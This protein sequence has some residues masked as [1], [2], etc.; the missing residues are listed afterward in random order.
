[1][2]GKGGGDFLNTLGQLVIPQTMAGMQKYRMVEDAQRKEDGQDWTSRLLLGGMSPS[3]QMNMQSFPKLP[4]GTPDIMAMTKPKDAAPSPILSDLNQ[5]KMLNSVLGPKNVIES[6]VAARTKAAQPYDLAEGASRFVGNSLVATNPKAPPKADLVTIKMP[7]GGVKSFN[8]ATQQAEIGS[9]LSGGGVEVNTPASQVNINNTPVNAAL[10]DAS[11]AALTGRRESAVGAFGQLAALDRQEQALNDGLKTGASTDYLA[12]GN[13][14][15]Q[16]LGV[17]PETANKIFGIVPT[18]AADFDS[19]SK[20]MTSAYIKQL[21]ANPSNSDLEFAKQMM[22]QL[23][24]NPQAAPLL[25]DR[26]RQK[27]KGNIGVYRKMVSSLGDD[28]S[29]SILRSELDAQEG[30]YNEQKASTNAPRPNPG[31]PAPGVPNGN[32][33]QSLPSDAVSNDGGKTYTS[34]SYPGKIIRPQ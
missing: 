19:A 22:P 4:D 11:K 34:P 14:W 7:G 27:A 26:I 25:I 28:P 12:W 33:I 20:E 9:A 16:S 31:K 21:G 8:A 24:T 30:A 3:P 13:N 1:M 2:A 6:M 29:A 18:S 17:A 32:V 10:T 15:A 5:S 23:R